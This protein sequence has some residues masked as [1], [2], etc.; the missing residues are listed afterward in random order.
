[1]VHVWDLI[2]IYDTVN[3]VLIY[4]ITSTNGKTHEL[5]TPRRP[6]SLPHVWARGMSVEKDE[7]QL[8]NLMIFAE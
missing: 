1:M 2:S 3:N 6:A 8:D 7:G 5:D 4:S